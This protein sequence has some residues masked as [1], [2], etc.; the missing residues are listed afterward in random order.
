MGQV[1]FYRITQPE[2]HPDKRSRGS[3]LHD[4]LEP[5]EPMQV[6]TRSCAAIVVGGYLLFG[7]IGLI[8]EVQLN[9]Y[10]NGLAHPIRQNDIS[11]LNGKRIFR[12]D[13]RWRQAR[14]PVWLG[15]AALLM[16][17]CSRG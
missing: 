17:L 5:H 9:K 10:A 3:Y 14:I 4:Y 11:S 6:I 12:W 16:L 1:R 13:R 15:L 2:C 8:F 7:A